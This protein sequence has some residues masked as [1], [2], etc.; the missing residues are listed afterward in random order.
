MKKKEDTRE[1]IHQAAEIVKKG[2]VVA[3]PTE[4]VYGLGADAF[5]P[6][7]VARIFEVKNRPYFDPLIVHIADFEEMS[8]LVIDIPPNAEKIDPTMLA[9]AADD[10]TL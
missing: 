4:T 5:N 7:A 6:L 8:R 9:W 10:R 2:G 3:L 1:A